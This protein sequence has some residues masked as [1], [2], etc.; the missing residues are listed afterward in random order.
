MFLVQTIQNAIVPKLVPYN[1]QRS[2][3]SD[4]VFLCVSAPLRLSTLNC[5]LCLNITVT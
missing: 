1:Q 3:K 2:Y 4:L 5:Q